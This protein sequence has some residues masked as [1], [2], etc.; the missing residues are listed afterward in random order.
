[1]C[2]VGRCSIRSKAEIATQPSPESCLEVKADFDPVLQCTDSGVR[3]GVVARFG[4]S[5]AKN[6]IDCEVVLLLTSR[7]YFLSCYGRRASFRRMRDVIGGC[8]HVETAS[9]ENGGSSPRGDKGRVIERREARNASIRC[10][11]SRSLMPSWAT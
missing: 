11:T 10:P 4:E 9:T 3:A 2:Y 1:M 8:L 6:D 5:S 7:K